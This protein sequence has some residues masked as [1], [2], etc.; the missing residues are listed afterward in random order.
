[1]D[2]SELCLRTHPGMEGYCTMYVHQNYKH[3]TQINQSQNSFHQKSKIIFGALSNNQIFANIAIAILYLLI[4]T[5][6]YRS[7]SLCFIILIAFCILCHIFF[8]VLHS[9][10]IIINRFPTIT[11]AITLDLSCSKWQ[12]E[13]LK[14]S[15][16]YCH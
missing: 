8:S 1:M 9:N 11:T 14:K 4:S 6:I 15:F 2:T 5:Q 12:Q 10:F 7:L 13:K 3:I 16:C